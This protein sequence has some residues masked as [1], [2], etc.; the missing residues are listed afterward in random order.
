MRAALFF[1]LALVAAGIFTLAA[2]DAA[3]LTISA[4]VLIALALPIVAALV[5]APAAGTPKERST[6]LPW[7]WA[8]LFGA[9]VCCVSALALLL[10]ADEP[11]WL[12]PA[13]GAA[14]A[15]LV[16]G[17]FYGIWLAPMRAISRVRALAD[18]PV[19]LA[20][21]V[22]ELVRSFA[23]PVPTG[24]VA[25]QR[26]ALRALTATGVLMDVLRFDE[27]ATVIG[28]VDPA[29]V[30]GEVR[31]ALLATRAV[32]AM[33]SGASDAAFAA[34]K[35]AAVH[36]R[37]KPLLD[38]LVLNDALLEAQCGRGD[39]ALDRLS[40]IEPPADPLRK[41]SYLLAKAHALAA[42]GDLE[43]ARGVVEEIARLAPR[44]LVRAAHL[45]GPAQALFTEQLPAG[46]NRG[47][48]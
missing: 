33:H 46:L 44:S 37:S 1:L 5:L 22:R 3:P 21:A 31:A 45:P 26:R 47:D 9:L 17:L 16:F 14:L 29:S 4:T 40:R 7:A 10:H 35:E 24:R 38:L 8:S 13:L 27:A 15:A 43:G 2:R 18:D 11:W 12:P 48:A 39:D 34:L 6:P 28:A 23:P 19:R 20:P 42:R 36:A 41:R 25:R 30:T 32:V